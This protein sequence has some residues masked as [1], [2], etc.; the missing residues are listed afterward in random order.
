M[1]YL[2]LSGGAD[3]V[4]LFHQLKSGFTAI[5]INHNQNQYDI[6]SQ[7]FVEEL[8]KSRQIPLII[9]NVYA[10]NETNARE[11]RYNEFLKIVQDNQLYLGHHLEDSV[12]T[13]LLNIFNGSSLLGARGIDSYSNYKGMSIYRPNIEAKLSKEFIKKELVKNGHE[14]VEDNSNYDIKIKRN[15]IRHVVLPHINKMFPNAINKIND[16]A[17]HCQIQSELNRK[18]AHYTNLNMKMC[19]DNMLTK[20]EYELSNWF[21]YRTQLKG[22]YLTKRHFNEFN[23]FIKSK[24][25]ICQLDCLLFTKN[26]NILEINKKEEQ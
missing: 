12:E 8:C 4:F 7:A 26:N 15:F 9:V 3:S 25:I 14:W 23:N 21:F 24:G 13:T 22:V 17:K 10:S 19:I 6:L 18:L 16:F 5:H 20:D 1:K 11:L 2:G